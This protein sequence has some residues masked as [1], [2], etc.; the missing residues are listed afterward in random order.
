LLWLIFR[1]R[2]R[3]RQTNCV[4]ENL[5]FLRREVA[6]SS[7]LEGPHA[8]IGRHSAQTLDRASHCLLA[9]RRQPVELRIHRAE[10]LLLLRRQVLPCFH[11]VKHLLL[12]VWG[13]TIEMLQALLEL[14]L[15][16]RRQAAKCGIALQ[17][18]PLL[19]ERLFTI[20]IQPLTRM[21]ALLRRLI[22]PWDVVARLWLRSWTLRL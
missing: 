2:G 19:V 3:K 10:L 17:R 4:V 13:Q 14:L 1:L 5:L 9:I 11:A 20:T 21:M 22:W 12:P 16:L 15:P 7:R 8:S 18:A 6:E